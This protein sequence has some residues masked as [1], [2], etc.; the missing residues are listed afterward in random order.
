MKQWMMIVVAVLTLCS[1]CTG[2]KVYAHYNPTSMIGWD[3]ADQLSFDVP[4]VKDSGLYA[5]ALGLRVNDF[6]P[7]TSLTL[8]VEQKI[9]PARQVRQDTLTFTLVDD[10]GS[11]KG[12]GVSTYQYR[13]PVSTLAL[14]QGDSLHITV[15]HNMKQ[16]I[17]TGITDVGIEVTRR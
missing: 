2:R 9:L 10:K 1:A 6:Y 17:L 7:F 14:H 13:L 12:Q 16:E 5:T 11:V 15:R 4:A 3:R 8:I